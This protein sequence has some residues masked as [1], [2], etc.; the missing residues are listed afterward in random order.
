MKKLLFILL[1]LGVALAGCNYAQTPTKEEVLQLLNKEIGYPKVV[2]Y[3]I[4]CSDPEH[5]RKLVEAELE[6]NSLIV[7]QNTQKLKDAGKALVQFTEKANPYL[8]PTPEKDKVLDIQKVKIADEEISEIS[9]SPDGD[10]SNTVWV[11]YSSVYKNITPFSV[12][13]NKGLNDPAKR[14]VKLSLSEDGWVLEK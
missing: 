9:I 5:A 7:V 13:M 4:F 6:T 1:S 10:N 3:E 2:D 12:L 11:E 8:L 14:K